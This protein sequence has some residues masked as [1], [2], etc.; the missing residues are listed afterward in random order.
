MLIPVVAARMEQRNEAAGRRILR[1]DRG[2]LVGIALRASESQ[3]LRIVARAGPFRNDVIDG[4]S[5]D[6]AARR[7]VAIFA[8]MF[9]PCRDFR[10]TGRRK[11]THS[12]ASSG[13]ASLSLRNA[14]SEENFSSERS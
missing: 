1:L 5:G 8:P 7:Q 3:I 14:S 13:K 9:G 11:E 6:L 4:E 10:S 2:P 12:S